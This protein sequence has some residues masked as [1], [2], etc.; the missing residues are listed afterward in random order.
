MQ[1]TS[2]ATQVETSHNVAKVYSMVVVLLCSVLVKHTY[3]SGLHDSTAFHLSKAKEHQAAAQ[4]HLQ[5][6]MQATTTSPQ[7]TGNVFAT[8]VEKEPADSMASSQHSERFM[9]LKTRVHGVG[10][11]GAG[12]LA[13][14][15][16]RL[17]K[18]NIAASAQGAGGFSHFDKADVEEYRGW[19]S[20]NLL[21]K[22][23]TLI[24]IDTAGYMVRFCFSLQSFPHRLSH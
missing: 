18:V 4:M 3:A 5:K 11:G 14:A 10:G 21:G 12:T 16:P 17:V 8:S 9:E 20:N 22:R 6:A 7:H 15:T 2:R 24:A 19:G 23:L 1:F 13:P